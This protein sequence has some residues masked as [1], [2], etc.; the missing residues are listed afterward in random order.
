MEG[1]KLRLPRASGSEA[2]T[3]PSASPRVSN[4]AIPHITTDVPQHNSGQ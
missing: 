2:S 4:G 3:T 1:D